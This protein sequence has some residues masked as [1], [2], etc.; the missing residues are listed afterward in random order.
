MKQKK[1][2]S[3][4]YVFDGEPYVIT[5]DT[6][7]T[8]VYVQAHLFNGYKELNPSLNIKK[9]NYNAIGV[10]KPEYYDYLIQEDETEVE[11]PTEVETPTETESPTEVE[12][13]TETETPTEPEG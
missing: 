6:D 2:G 1:I 7:A 9:I 13:P 10:N 12:T 3:K 5:E 8:V 11:S 4:L